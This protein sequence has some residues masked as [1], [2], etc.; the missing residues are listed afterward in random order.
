MTSNSTSAV[1]SQVTSQYLI[2]A[3]CITSIASFISNPLNILVFL[4]LKSFRTNRSAL[5]LIVESIS[6]FIC[7][8]MTFI[9]TLVPLVYN[10]MTIVTSTIWCKLRL[11]IFQTSILTTSYMICLSACDQL[12][13]TNHR[14][15]LRQLYTLK[16]ARS[17]VAIGVCFNVVHSILYGLCVG[18]HPLLGCI[19]LN[20]IWSQYAKYIY[21]PLLAGF[22]PILIASTFSL[23]AYGNVRRIIRRQIPLERRRFDRQITAMVLVRVIAFVLLQLPYTSYRVYSINI[24]PQQIDQLR[25]TIERLIQTVSYSLI[26]TNT[27]INLYLF[28]ITSARYRRQVKY[29]LKKKCWRT[30]KAWVSQSENQVY[31]ECTTFS[32][33]NIDL[34]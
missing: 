30:I 29:V 6:N 11:V 32:D 5:Y 24:N 13:S 15:S 31:P 28:L 4:R 2:Y 19:I 8:L 22:V 3:N 16:T 23:I 1:I 7:G 27:A 34:D 14:S 18:S 12:F 17:L 33:D 26:N 20:P 25:A 21:Y 9:I 10:D